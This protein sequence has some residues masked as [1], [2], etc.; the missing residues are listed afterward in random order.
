M[1]GEEILRDFRSVE[2]LRETTDGLTESERTATKRSL[3]GVGVVVRAV[4]PSRVLLANW[5][6]Q[7]RN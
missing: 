6:R 4:L 1:E 5:H 3:T 7:T 2:I